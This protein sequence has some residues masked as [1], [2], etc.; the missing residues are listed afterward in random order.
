MALALVTAPAT[1]PVTLT[2]AK[3]HLRVDYSADDTYITT[4]ISVARQAAEQIL[5]RQLVTATWDLFLD[6]FP[7]GCGR[8]LDELERYAIRVPLPRL[9]SVTWVKYYDLED[10]LQTLSASAYVVDATSEPARITPA[11]TYTWPETREELSAV[12]VRF[13]AGYG[14]AAAVPEGV[15]QWILLRIGSMFAHREEEITVPNLASLGFADRL[16]DPYRVTRFV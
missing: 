3:A 9:Q 4:L 5:G 1:E 6:R 11:Y 16:L 8:V 13:Q 10:V 14:A 12:N 7:D 15:K 2:E